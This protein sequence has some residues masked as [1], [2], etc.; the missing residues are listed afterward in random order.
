[1]WDCRAKTTAGDRALLAAER[2]GGA[3][4]R[5]FNSAIRVSLGGF[6]PRFQITPAMATSLMAIEGARRAVEGLPVDLA[7]LQGLRETARRVTTHHSTRIEGNR[8]SLAEVDAALAGQRFPGRERDEV[9]VRHYY[10]AIEEVD[11]L[12]AEDRPLRETD[13]RR[14]HALA[15]AGR[16]IQPR[17]DQLGRVDRVRV[18]VSTLRSH[19]R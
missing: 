6:A 1:M 18:A 11:T 9:E 8:L 2:P 13:V 4:C 12:A 5:R 3:I 17:P 16:R 15:F 14:L 7:V 19:Q 10:R